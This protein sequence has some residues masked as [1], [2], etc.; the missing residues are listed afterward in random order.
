MSMSIPSKSFKRC[1]L[2]IFKIGMSEKYPSSIK[3]IA[4]WL[5]GSMLHIHT[6]Y[7]YNIIESPGQKV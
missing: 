6:E 2:N 7:M 1:E 3:E 5:S 4:W